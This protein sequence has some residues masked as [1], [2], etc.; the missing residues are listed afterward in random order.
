MYPKIKQPIIFA[1]NVASGMLNFD[2]T[3]L[4][5]YLKVAPSPP[6]KNTERKLIIH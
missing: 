3:R 6:P 1:L 5:K 4:M 2:K